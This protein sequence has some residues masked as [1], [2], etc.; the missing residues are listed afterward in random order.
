MINGLRGGNG[1]LGILNLAGL[2]KKV[3]NRKSLFG[4]NI[5]GSPMNNGKAVRMK[6]KLCV[7]QKALW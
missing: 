6:L 2:K 3:G 5:F 7:N 4:Q 1:K